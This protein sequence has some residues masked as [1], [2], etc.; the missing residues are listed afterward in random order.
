MLGHFELWIYIKAKIKNNFLNLKNTDWPASRTQD[1][2]VSSWSG[3]WSETPWL[4]KLT[5]SFPV[6]P[7]LPVQTTEVSGLKSLKTFILLLLIVLARIFFF[8]FCIGMDWLFLGLRGKHHSCEG[9]I[10]LICSLLLIILFAHLCL[11]LP[12]SHSYAIMNKLP[13]HGA[14]VTHLRLATVISCCFASQV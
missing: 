1:Y 3:T 13:G 2:T 10:S 11:V 7:L 14:L 9:V 4:L 5:L 6:P 8:F 12:C